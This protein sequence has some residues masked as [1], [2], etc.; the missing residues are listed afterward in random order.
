MTAGALLNTGSFCGL[1]G[2]TG[3]TCFFASSSA[4]LAS[5]FAC[6]I[7]AAYADNS[8]EVAVILLSSTFSLA[9]GPSVMSSNISAFLLVL[10]HLQQLPHG[11]CYILRAICGHS[12]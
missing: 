9:V 7:L 3:L 12:L 5:A 11:F 6:S 10:L 2:T 8:A 4:R 1:L